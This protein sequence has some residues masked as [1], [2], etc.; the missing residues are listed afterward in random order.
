MA[1]CPHTMDR[2]MKTVKASVSA[3]A[4]GNVR[5][6]IS[7][8]RDLYPLYPHQA[9]IYHHLTQPHLGGCLLVVLLPHNIP[10]VLS[11][12][13]RMDQSGKTDTLRFREKKVKES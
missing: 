6:P 1:F 12:E 11:P 3:E 2:K 13:W 10:L 9:H 5:S 4:N 8:K 7:C